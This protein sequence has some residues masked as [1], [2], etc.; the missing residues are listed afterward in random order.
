[1]IKCFGKPDTISE[2]P[3]Q[4]I[5]KKNIYI[6]IYIVKASVVM[7]CDVTSTCIWFSIFPESLVGSTSRVEP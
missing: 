3:G 4:Q 2:L 5:K 1:M 6:Y 7:E